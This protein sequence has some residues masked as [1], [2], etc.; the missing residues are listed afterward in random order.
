METLYNFCITVSEI[1]KGWR[2]LNRHDRIQEFL[3]DLSQIE[4]LHLDQKSAELSGLIH[5]DLESTGQ[6]IGLADVL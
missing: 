6:P 5:A 3:A 4:I 1:V 2:K